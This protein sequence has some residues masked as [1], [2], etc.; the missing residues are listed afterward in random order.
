[1][2]AIDDAEAVCPGVLLEEVVEGEDLRVVVI[3]YEVIAAAV[4]RPA[5][6]I[7]DG[8]LTASQLIEKQSRRRAAA[9]GGESVIPLDD[10][11]FDTLA[12]QG[13]APH[14]VIPEGEVIRVRRTANLHTGGTIHDVTSALH[15]TLGEAAVHAARVLDIPVV[16][17]DLL[18][19]DVSAPDYVIIEANERP[20]LAN[21]E[22]Q[23]TAEAFLDLLFPRT[24]R[25]AIPSPR[26]PE[27]ESTP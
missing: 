18:V 2:R 11:T 16:G 17:M 24:R 13:Y 19:A 25:P 4:R 6:V 20:G 23:P 22:P 1:M 12:R 15:P 7:G 27:E 21:H 26:P 9:T 5:E 3:D 8:R 10:H 14:D